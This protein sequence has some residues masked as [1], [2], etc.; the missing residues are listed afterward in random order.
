MAHLDYYPP[1]TIRT[2]NSVGQATEFVATWMKNQGPEEVA[3]ELV[4]HENLPKK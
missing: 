3:C 1:V 2:T 4:S